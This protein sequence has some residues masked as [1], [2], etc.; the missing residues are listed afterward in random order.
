[1]RKLLIVSGITILSLL[2]GCS[3]DVGAGSNIVSSVDSS[4]SEID[5]ANIDKPK[6]IIVDDI[7]GLLDGDKEVIERYFGE[8]DIYTDEGVR[9]RVS[10]AKVVFTGVGGEVKSEEEIDS[11]GGL[12]DG[13]VELDIHICTLDYRATN[14]AVEEI[15]ERVKREKVGI[16][17]EELSDRVSEEV[18]IRAKNGEFD[19]HISLPVKVKYVGGEGKVEVTEELKVALTGGWYNAI[20][21]EIESGECPV[22]EAIKQSE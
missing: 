21:A 2:V 6:D 4:V 1:M 22:L 5:V 14:E 8:S 7:N 3:G 15:T 18:A 12:V 16:S 11:I 13:E 20:G 19:I 17:E 9:D 10:V